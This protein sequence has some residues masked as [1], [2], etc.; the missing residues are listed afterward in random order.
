M[1]AVPL[2]AKEDPMDRSGIFVRTW[3]AP[4]AMLLLLVGS[5]SGADDWLSISPNGQ[6]VKGKLAA[7]AGGWIAVQDVRFSGLELTSHG[8]HVRH[9][10]RAKGVG[11]RLLPGGGSGVSPFCPGLPLSLAASPGPTSGL[12]AMPGAGC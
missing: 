5:A 2:A 12:A 6:V 11:S 8:P 9:L 3:I 10:C 4:L 7:P 1:R